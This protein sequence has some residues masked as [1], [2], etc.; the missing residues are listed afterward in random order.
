[1]SK[2]LDVTY[3]ETSP[4]KMRMK[5]TKW[6]RSTKAKA[7]ETVPKCSSD[8]KARPKCYQFYQ[9]NSYIPLTLNSECHEISLKASGICENII[10]DIRYIQIDSVVTEIWHFV[11]LMRQIGSNWRIG[12]NHGNTTEMALDDKRLMSDDCN[13]DEMLSEVSVLWRFKE[14]K[15]NVEFCCVYAQFDLEIDLDLWPWPLTV[16]KLC[17]TCRGCVKI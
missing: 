17:Q 5:M 10:M 8:A 6:M 12:G 9:T 1:M 11:V 16:T 2:F 4:I 3:S 14:K 15:K 13:D 7:I